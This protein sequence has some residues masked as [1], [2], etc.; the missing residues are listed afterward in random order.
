MIMTEYCSN[1]RSSLRILLVLLLVSSNVACRKTDNPVADRYM[2]DIAVEFSAQSYDMGTRASSYSSGDILGSW[3]SAS[4]TYTAGEGIGVFAFYQKAKSNG[5]PVTFGGSFTR[6]DFMYNQKI[7][8]STSDGTLYTCS[9]SPR[10]YWPNNINDRLSFFAYAPYDISTA[11]EDLEMVAT[12]DGS[13]ITRHYSQRRLPEEQVDW[14]WADP[15]LN[16]DKS[17]SGSPIS[18]SF[19]HICPRVG[20][21]CIADRDDDDAYVTVDR[22]VLTAA[23]NDT[24]D[25]VY[26]TAAGS[27]GWE[28]LEATYSPV[29]YVIFNE[30]GS[31]RHRVRTYETVVGGDSSYIFPLPGTQDITL[32]V[33]LTLNLANGTT[34]SKQISQTISSMALEEGR[35]YDLRLDIKPSQLSFD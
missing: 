5:Y 1:R 9:Y 28:N 6:P 4:S 7:D 35:A 32:T 24:G 34:K 10:K 3:D 26:R 11:W 17:G 33:T 19:R 14:L 13:K 25:M 12:Q 23:F 2:S 18:F 22:V 15:V 16:L 8:V 21:S 27:S 29:D 31:D 20:V 30:T